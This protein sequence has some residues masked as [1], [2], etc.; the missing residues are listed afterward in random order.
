MMTNTTFAPDEQHGRR[1]DPGENGGVVARAAGQA[2][3]LGLMYSGG[4]FQQA[5][6]LARTANR[7]GLLHKLRGNFQM[8]RTMLYV[9]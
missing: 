7:R 9:R 3:D 5:R 8:A 6:Q 4:A 2:D 1:G